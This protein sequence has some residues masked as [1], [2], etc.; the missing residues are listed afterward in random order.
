MPK[1]RA[2]ATTLPSKIA[3]ELSRLESLYRK[4]SD[5][6]CGV[7][8][9]KTPE[10]LKRAIKESCQRLRTLKRAHDSNR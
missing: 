4:R 7:S 5:Y 9:A 2:T 10:A 8:H 3:D 6:Y 1:T